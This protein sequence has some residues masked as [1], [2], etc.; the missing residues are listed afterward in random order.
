MSKVQKPKPE[1]KNMKKAIPR[2]GTRKK[3]KESAKHNA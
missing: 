2:R 1:M 3:G